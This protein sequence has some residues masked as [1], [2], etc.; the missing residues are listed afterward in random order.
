MNRL[1][2]LLK[3]GRKETEVAFD[4]RKV[5]S[6]EN[7]SMEFCAV[8]SGANSAIPHL[9]TTSKKISYGDFIVVD[10]SSIDDSGYYADFTR[11]YSMGSPSSG[12]EKVYETVRNAQAAALESIAVRNTC[13]K[14]GSC[15]A[16]N[17]RKWWLW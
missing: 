1:P 8:Q 9:E 2:E 4:V 17:H 14:G 16:R 7:V 3:P 10:I 5:L 15:R 11:T 6:E 13:K 12:A